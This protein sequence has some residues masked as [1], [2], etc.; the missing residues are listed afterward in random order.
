MTAPDPITHRDG[1]PRHPWHDGRRLPVHVACAACQR[2]W[3][4]YGGPVPPQGWICGA[5]RTKETSCEV[6]F[7]SSS[8]SV[9]C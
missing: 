9:C 4:I 1:W 6:S 2:P 5:C 3:R 8:R 7:D